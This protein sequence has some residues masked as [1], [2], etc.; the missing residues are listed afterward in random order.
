MPVLR[1][2]TYNVGSVRDRAAFARA[3]RDAQ[4]DVVCVQNAP[5]RLRWRSK[6]AA[7]ARTSGLVVVGG[8]R[9]AG[10]NL[11]MSSL[12]VEVD[13]VHDLR[14]GVLALLRYRDARF[15][16]AGTRTR[17]AD[18]QDAIVRLVPHATPTIVADERGLTAQGAQVLETSELLVPN[19]HRPVLAEIELPV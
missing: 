10:A 9:V 5:H 11:M 17:S 13:A 16:V 1:V 15:A 3:V 12:S 4:P 8:G 6:C 7:L 14:D 19:G 18:L 2:V